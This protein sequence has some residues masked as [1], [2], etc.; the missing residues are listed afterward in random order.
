M[1]EM[2][3][4]AI[5]EKEKIAEGV[6]TSMF[7]VTEPSH[8]VQ[9]LYVN[10]HMIILTPAFSFFTTTIVVVISIEIIVNYNNNIIDII[11]IIIIVVS[12]SIEINIFIVII[13]LSTCFFLV[14]FII[15]FL[16]PRFLAVLLSCCLSYAS[17]SKEIGE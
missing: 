16:F 5:L 4:M 11:I 14:N 15:A 2:L 10:R 13:I 17:F 8:I 12:S 6:L 1:L 9:P 3:C 7:H